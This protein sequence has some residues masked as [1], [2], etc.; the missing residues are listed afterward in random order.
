MDEEQTSR[1]S[2]QRML[3]LDVYNQ[4]IRKAAWFTQRPFLF[5][6][7]QV[8]GRGDAKVLDHYNLLDK[9]LAELASL[10]IRDILFLLLLIT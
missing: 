2:V 7:R 4:E 9:Y 3:L 5:E 1:S 10:L 6:Q 8:I